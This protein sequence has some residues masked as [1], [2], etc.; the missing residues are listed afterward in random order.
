MAVNIVVEATKSKQ[1]HQRGQSL[2]ATVIDLFPSDKSAARPHRFAAESLTDIRFEPKGESIVKRIVPR[3]GIGAL[4]GASQ[5][6][7]SFLALDLSLH[8]A[9]GWDWAGRRV[10]QT[11]TIY[12]AA[13]GAAGLR[14]RTV[15]FRMKH[16][17]LP[18][19]VPYRLISSAPN[20]GTS[21]GDLT[22]LIEGI[23]ASGIKPGLIVIDT[24]AQS[25]GGS[26]E[27]G[28]GMVQF[29]ANAT[30]L[31]NYFRAFVLVVHHVGLNDAKRMRGHSSLYAGSDAVILCERQI[32]ELSSTLTLQKLKDDESNITFRAQMSRVVIGHDEDGD[33][34]STL[35]VD[36]IDEFS[37]VERE[38]ATK[39]R[40]PLPAAAKN[41]LTALRM[42]IG[43]LGAAPPPHDMVPVGI[44]AVTLDQWREH[45][46]RLGISGSEDERARKTAFNRAFD[47]LTEEK[48]IAAWD[49]H[50]WI[51]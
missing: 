20:L 36:R 29:V 41:A 46:F 8:A 26:D 48:K 49:E 50:V 32:G 21:G 18:T 44:K 13:E 38:T 10:T 30:A 51:V 28:S 25:L 37:A 47:K 35:V 3:Q 39:K 12:I 23:E 45:A 5:S 22:L 9:A 2:N 34:I 7:K 19:D 1:L 16:A 24:L 40:R 6:L 42:A 11:P 43:K 15:G 4:F 14:K 33:E 17:E 27:N 31:A